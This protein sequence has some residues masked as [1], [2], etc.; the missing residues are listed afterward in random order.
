MN[1]DRMT[2]REARVPKMPGW[3][4]TVGLSLLGA[5]ALVAVWQMFVVPPCGRVLFAAECPVGSTATFSN[6]L[7]I[8]GQT[9]STITV[10]GAPTINRTQTL[11]DVTDTFV[12]RA[13]T[14]TLTNKTFDALT[15]NG[16]LSND[17]ATESTSTVTGSIHTDGGLG[18][19]GDIYAG[20]DIF[21]TSGAVLDFDSSNVTITHSATTLTLDGPTDLNM[22]L[23]LAIPSGN[24]SSVISLQ[25]PASGNGASGVQIRQGDGSGDSNNMQYTIR[26]LGGSNYL[27]LMS[28]D[29]DNSSTN[30]DVWRITD[31]TDDVAFLGGVGIGASTAPTAGLVVGSPTGGGQGAGTINAVAVYDDGVLLTD[32]VSDAYKGRLDAA[33]LAHYDNL[34]P[35]R[36]H[37]AKF[38]PLFDAQGRQVGNQEIAPAFTVTRNHDPARAFAQRGN[39]V[40]DPIALGDHFL[41]TGSL[42]Q[43]VGETAWVA[44][45]RKSTGNV[46]QQLMEIVEVLV[47]QNYDQ[48]KEL[49]ALKAQVAALT[50]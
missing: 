43:F 27:H 2:L 14:D 21:L 50:P 37:G 39:W 18:V 16:V 32:Y 12:Y 11:Q 1:D 24:G 20:D 22:F 13:S 47:L 7:G 26:Y 9:T 40:F 49:D 6:N 48:A 5:L 3:A 30:G 23:T 15:V 4:K 46:I 31:G 41:T 25:Q 36:Q 19:F 28:E 44:G 8:Q 17:D 33:K 35:D 38:K 10:T 34:V 29:I 45:E 42:P